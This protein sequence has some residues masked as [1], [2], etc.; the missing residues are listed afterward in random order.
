MVR[1]TGERKRSREG[2]TERERHKTCRG[3]CRERG[4]SSNTNMTGINILS[5]YDCIEHKHY[6][7]MC[8]H[9]CWTLTDRNTDILKYI[10]AYKKGVT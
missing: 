6:L 3:K 1:E 7:S 8:D 5:T 10:K 9:A 4:Q 2:E